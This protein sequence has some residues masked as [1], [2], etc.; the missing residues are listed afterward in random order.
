MKKYDFEDIRPYRDEE[1]REVLDRVINDR[2]FLHAMGNFLVP[3]VYAV[4]PGL[5]RWLIRCVLK[6]ETR[7]VHDVHSFQQAVEKY[8]RHMIETTTTELTH[9]GLEH[10][11][12]DQNYLFISN[13]RDIAM[14]PAFVNWILYHNGMQTVRIAIGDNLLTKAYAS[15]LMR[16]N[17]SFLVNRS[18]TAPKK[19]FVAL[20]KLSAYIYHSVVEERANVWIA[21]R[22]GRAKDGNDKTEPAI[23]K[24]I[25]MAKPKTG[26]FSDYVRS[27][28]IVPVAISYEWDPCDIAKA[29]ELDAKRQH[30]SYEKEQHEDVQSIANGISGQKGHVHVAFGEVLEADYE[31][32]EAVAMEIDRQI[33]ANY[34]LHP[35]NYLA[36]EKNNLAMDVAVD[37]SILENKAALFEQRVASCSA[38][39]RDILVDMYANPIVAKST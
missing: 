13:H 39:A 14:D 12:A 34:R 38:S 29:E 32:A 33:H 15:D 36:G 31:D 21:Q 7:R 10:L 22:E 9:S 19:I 2:E 3:G 6:W 23:I 30:G 37:P 11:Q 5:I 28:K 4:F 18:E 24:M 8:M 26:E 27:L 35:S 20:K 16:L 1:A 25:A 17:K